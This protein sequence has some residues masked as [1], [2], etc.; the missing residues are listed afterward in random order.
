MDAV[1]IRTNKEITPPRSSQLCDYTGGLWKTPK[2]FDRHKLII[3]ILLLVK[4]SKRMIWSMAHCS[5]F[6]SESFLKL[7]AQSEELNHKERPFS[8]TA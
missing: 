5:Y 4:A 8:H 3:L 7:P 2:V 6:P 1:E